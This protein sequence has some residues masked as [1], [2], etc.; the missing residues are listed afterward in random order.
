MALVQEQETLLL[1]GGVCLDTFSISELPPLCLVANTKVESPG[2]TTCL[3][4]GHCLDSVEN[5]TVGLPARLVFVIVF[6]FLFLACGETRVMSLRSRRPS[7][8]AALPWAAAFP[9]HTSDFSLEVCGVP[10][11]T[12]I[13]AVN[14]AR[15]EVTAVP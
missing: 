1:G 15:R 11:S 4:R 5:I 2:S 6:C 9:F 12:D 8:L 14:R 3:F 7:T 13:L 10:S